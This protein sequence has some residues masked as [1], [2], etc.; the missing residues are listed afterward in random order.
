MA[1]NQFV[2]KNP[3]RILSFSER[4]H[5]QSLEIEEFILKNLRLHETSFT[6]P[7]L[8]RKVKQATRNLK[9]FRLLACNLLSIFWRSTLGIQRPTPFSG[10][11]T[12]LYG[13]VN[14]RP[15]EKV[16]AFYFSRRIQKVHSFSK[17][18]QRHKWKC[19]DC[20][21]TASENK[22]TLLAGK[23]CRELQGRVCVAF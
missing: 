3:C 11:R 17:L 18:S 23:L 15:L 21:H 13:W 9:K 12:F 14:L 10:S 6:V 8:E 20:A 4:R 5:T 1:T 2:Q 19:F 7:H 22:T 16:S